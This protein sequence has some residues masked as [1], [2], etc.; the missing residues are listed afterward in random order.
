MY[1]MSGTGTRLQVWEGTHLRTSGNL[2][3]KDLKK[4]GSKIVSI[5]ASDAAKANA[6]KGGG[7][8]A[9][10]VGKDVAI[11]LGP[12]GGIGLIAKAGMEATHRRRERKRKAKNAGK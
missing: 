1:N 4:V 7:F 11:S 6:A 9:A 5:R 10:K 12:L 3:K 8:N 2:R